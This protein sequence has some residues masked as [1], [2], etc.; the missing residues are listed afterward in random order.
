METKKPTSVT[1][2]LEQEYQYKNCFLGVELWEF[3][4][5]CFLPTTSGQSF[6]SLGSGEPKILF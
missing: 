6:A 5:F 3:S 2:A 4:I 1:F